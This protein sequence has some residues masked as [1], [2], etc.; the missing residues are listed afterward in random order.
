VATAPGAVQAAP[1]STAGPR[2]AEVLHPIERES[3]EIIENNRDWSSFDPLQ[4][5]ILQRLVHTSGDFEIV[6]D[7]FFSAGA[8]EAGVRAVQD[9][10]TLLTDVTMVQSGLRRSALAALGLRTACL[11]HDEETR[12]VADNNGI[13]RSAA[14]IRRGWLK[15]GNDVVVLVGDAPTAVEETVRLIREQNWRPRLVVGLP[16]GFVGTREC[17][18]NLRRCLHVPRITN[19]GTRGGSP[20]A[21]AAMNALL[22]GALAAPKRAVPV[23]S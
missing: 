11:V 2:P 17:K 3:F 18:E 23:R 8:P 5:A 4:K 20:W 15:F 6:G 7:I 21:A 13:T 16:V 9:R 12:L 10:C 19:R 14:G 1:A 22:L